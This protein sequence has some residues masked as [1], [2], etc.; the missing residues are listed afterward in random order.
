M[1]RHLT[2]WRRVDEHLTLTDEHA[3]TVRSAPVRTGE[4][5]EIEDIVLD[6]CSQTLVKYHITHIDLSTTRPLDNAPFN[7]G[8]SSIF[9][10]HMAC[11][12]AS[13]GCHK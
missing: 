11:G 8:S 3:E 1:R 6:V 7:E 2:T 10:E 4:D 9:E 13:Q 5:V 12:M